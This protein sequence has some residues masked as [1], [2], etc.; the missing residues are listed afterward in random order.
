M[1]HNSEALGSASKAS[2]LDRQLFALHDKFLAERPTGAD[3]DVHM[4]PSI[5]E[6]II[7]RCTKPGDLVLDPFAGFGTT[8][9]RAVALDRHAVGL[10]LLPERA[11]YL[12]HRVPNA[13][14]IQGDARQLFSTLGRS[15]ASVD[16]ILTSPPYMTAEHH[17]ADPLTGYEN[18]NGDYNRYLYELGLVAAQCARL[19]VPGGFVVW[20]VADIHYRGNTTQLIADCARVLAGYLSLV[21]ITEIIWD[22]YPHDLVAD[23][24]LV[25]QRSPVFQ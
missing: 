7:E 16:L 6:H 11:E 9:D 10:E 19:I 14:I 18:N 8:L 12:K 21:G 2:P 23:A 1:E 20:N 24:L 25:F 4:P 5:V 22:R 17:D 3:E 13:H 15:E